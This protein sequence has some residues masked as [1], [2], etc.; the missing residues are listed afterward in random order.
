MKATQQKL[1]SL[2][3]DGS[4][5]VVLWQQEMLEGIKS[6]YV[7]SRAENFSC[8]WLKVFWTEKISFLKQNITIFPSKKTIYSSLLFGPLFFF[9]RFLMIE[10]IYNQKVVQVYSSITIVSPFSPIA[11]VRTLAMHTSYKG[12]QRGVRRHKVPNW[13]DDWLFVSGALLLIVALHHF[14]RVLSLGH[15]NSIAASRG[16]FTDYELICVAALDERRVYS[17]NWGLPPHQQVIGTQMRTTVWIVYQP[18]K[19]LW[20]VLKNGEW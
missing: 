8:K 12:A 10:S 14:T 5:A 6:G 13:R 1:R 2:V 3:E 7:V 16:A 4:S 15:K 20:W 18:G 19:G 17:L 11:F 9:T